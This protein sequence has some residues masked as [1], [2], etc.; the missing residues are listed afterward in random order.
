RRGFDNNPEIAGRLDGCSALHGLAQAI[1]AVLDAPDAGI[2]V[3]VGALDALRRP[4]ARLLKKTVHILQD[5][6]VRDAADGDRLVADEFGSFELD[7]VG[8]G[9]LEPAAIDGDGLLVALHVTRLVEIYD[10]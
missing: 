7:R 8:V 5:V 9:R 6:R 3:A 2:G 4:L 1:D 10:A